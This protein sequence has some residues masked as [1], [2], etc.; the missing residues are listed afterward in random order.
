MNVGEI[1]SFVSSQEEPG[2][3]PGI[4]GIRLSAILLS[5]LL[6][7]SFPGTGGAAD[8]TNAAAEKTDE[9]AKTSRQMEDETR[10]KIL[11]AND[12]KLRGHE[13]L[14]PEQAKSLAK[15]YR[16]TAKMIV[17]QGC[18]PKPVLDAAA[19]F[20]KQSGRSER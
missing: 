2:G 13:S 4:N 20:E 7:F 11:Q 5:L 3:I 19:Y 14:F 1:Q 6:V 18:D 17:E 9:T 10:K 15:G 12:F 16:E 8:L